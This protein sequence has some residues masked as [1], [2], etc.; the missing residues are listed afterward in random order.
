M[1]ARRKDSPSRRRLERL[2]FWLI[3]AVLAAELWQSYGLW[4]FGFEVA[5][6]A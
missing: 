2:G 3:A 5:D 6:V 4:L 1:D